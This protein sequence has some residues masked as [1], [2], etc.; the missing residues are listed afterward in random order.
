MQ[1]WVDFA[2]FSH[3]ESHP[4]TCAQQMICKFSMRSPNRSG[5]TRARADDPGSRIQDSGIQ[6]HFTHFPFPEGARVPARAARRG[7]AR[8]PLQSAGVFDVW[9][10]PTAPR[11]AACVER[12]AGTPSCALLAARHKGLV[13][14]SRTASS[15]RE[16]LYDICGAKLLSI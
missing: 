11:G 1:K 6:F 13:A 7:R 2:V 4:C 12:I 16:L 15:A 8:R 10:P 14:Q 3:L 5:C 9:R